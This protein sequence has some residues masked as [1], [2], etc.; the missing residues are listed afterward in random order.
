MLILCYLNLDLIYANI[1]IVKFWCFMKRILLTFFIVFASI[2]CVAV[3]VFTKDDS[4]ILRNNAIECIIQPKIGRMMHLS[5]IGGENILWVDE[6]AEENA[7]EKHFWKNYGGL[8]VWLWKQNDWKKIYGKGW[9][10]P[11]EMD[12]GPYSFELIT[13]GVRLS[14]PVIPGY[15][16]QIVQEFIV[17]DDETKRVEHIVDLKHIS[18]SEKTSDACVGLWLVAQVPTVNTEIFAELTCADNNLYSLD[19]NAA[20]RKEKISDNFYRL[21]QEDKNANAKSGMM[22][23]KIVF[24]TANGT[25]CSFVRK[26]KSYLHKMG[27]EMQVFFS[28]KVSA[29]FSPSAGPYAE[30]EF[31]T[32]VFCKGKLHGN[33]LELY[34]ELEQNK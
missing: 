23:D 13:N 22:G 20:V 29:D 15:Q 27:E 32:E 18:P 14:S 5:L 7:P 11:R 19:S 2:Y 9:P 10:P 31:V 21:Y 34:Y 3:D 4:V 1:S 16:M 25:K 17:A 8:K 24:M 33:K 6:K 26:G 12:L 30:L 28:P